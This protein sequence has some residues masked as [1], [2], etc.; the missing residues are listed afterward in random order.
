M[1]IYLCVLTVSISF[2]WL[3]MYIVVCPF[4]WFKIIQQY[5]V[6]VRIETQIVSGLYY[7]VLRLPLHPTQ[8]FSSRV[9]SKD[10]GLAQ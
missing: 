6:W 3:D 2:Y 1:T 7:E 4:S 8:S 9:A 10:P 5:C